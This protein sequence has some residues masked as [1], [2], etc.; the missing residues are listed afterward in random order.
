[1]R[2]GISRSP[3]FYVGDKYKLIR[4]I[5]T[6]FPDHINRLIEPFVGG[7]SVMMNV[8]A[9]GFILN[10][11]DSYVIGLH[12]MLC[13]YV[14]REQDFYTEFYR[15]V[16]QYGLSLSFRENLVP[17]ELRKAHP[18]TY[19]AKYNKDAYRQ[20]KADFIAGAQQDWMQL[21]VLLIYGFNRMLRFNKRGLFNLP[22]GNVD[23]NQNTH[24]ALED[25][26]RVMA[27]KRVEWHNEDFRLFLDNINYQADDLVYL[28]PPYLITFSE[29]NKLWNNETEHDL[30]ALLDDMNARGIHFAI[31]NV[32]H[33]RGRTNTLFLDWSAQYHSHPINSNYISFNDNSIKQFNEV[34]VT[35]Y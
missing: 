22:V 5:R 9:D 10:D 21:Y 8:D 3:M 28:D 24:D 13:G 4:E 14:G 23:Y 27:T 26:F 30:L 12:R 25:Y 31:S 6:H 11:I 34:L 18:K 33:Y 19:F 20:L 7:G 15:I 29:Y 35:N 2:N 1:M 32:T 17:Q 16:D